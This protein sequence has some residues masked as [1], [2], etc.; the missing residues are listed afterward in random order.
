MRDLTASL[1]VIPDGIQS[2]PGSG[3]YVG[4]ACASRSRL[5]ALSRCGRDDA[6]VV[7]H[8]R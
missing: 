2:V 4:I 1:R 8:G 6:G 7:L 3:G 5:Y